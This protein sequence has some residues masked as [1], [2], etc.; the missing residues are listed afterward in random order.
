MKYRGI[1]FL[2]ISVIALVTLTTCGKRAVTPQGGITVGGTISTDRAA[3]AEI[4]LDVSDD[5]STIEKVSLVFTDLKCEGFTAGSM[6]T[7]VSGFTPITNGEFQYKSADIGEINGRFT[8]STSAEGT[9]HLAFYDGKAECGTSDWTA[10][11][12]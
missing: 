4:F 7:T 2:I 9:I 6:M 3:S 10:K 8:S 1:F 11:A 5:S 12:K